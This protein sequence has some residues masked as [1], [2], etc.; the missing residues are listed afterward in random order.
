MVK[1]KQAHKNGKI[2]YSTQAIKM[3]KSKSV[4][5]YLFIYLFIYLFSLLSTSNVTSVSF[6][7]DKNLNSN[8]NVVLRHFRIVL[9]F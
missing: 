9:F 1:N 7:L 2:I 8:I 4:Y 3:M 6:N 5:F